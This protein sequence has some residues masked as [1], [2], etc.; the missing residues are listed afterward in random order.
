VAFRSV[1]VEIA[2]SNI[3]ATISG[4]APAQLLDGVLNP[5]LPR[6]NLSDHAGL[7]GYQADLGAS[8]K[9]R[10]PN[11]AAVFEPFRS[12]CLTGAL[13]RL[14]RTLRRAGIRYRIRDHRQAPGWR[15]DWSLSEWRLRDYQE[16]VVQAALDSGRGLIDIGTS[17]G[18]SLLAAAIVARIG[19]PALFLVTTRTL[20]RQTA[21]NLR[22]YLGIEPGI[23]GDGHCS[24]QTI[25]VAL[26]QALEQSSADIAPW[27]N[28]VLVFDEGHHA[29]APTYLDLIRRIDPR[30]H[31]YLSAV[32]FRSGADQTVLDALAGPPLT[33]RRYSAA[34]LIEK[35]YASP[36]EVRIEFGR[37]DG[38]MFEKPFPMLYRDFIVHHHGRNRR[39][40]E[41]AC[42]AVTAGKS[43]LVLVERIEHGQL[44]H[45][46]LES[47]MHA[48]ALAAKEGTRAEEQSMVEKRP[49]SMRGGLPP[50]S[51]H[52]GLPLAFVHGGIARSELHQATSDFR[53]GRLRCLI[54]TTGLFQE[55]VSIDGIHVL[56][57]A[58]GFKSRAKVIQSVGRG[59]RRCPGKTSCLYVDFW[60]DDATGIFRSHSRQ[61]LRVLKEEG[62]AL[63]DMRAVRSMVE[64]SQAGEEAGRDPDDPPQEPECAWSS[65]CDSDGFERAR[66][67]ASKEGSDEPIPPMWTHIP[68]TKR[69]LEIDADGRVRRRAVCLKK[70]L[71]PK[72]I[73]DKCKKQNLCRQGGKIEWQDA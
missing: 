38:N 19:L 18:K 68:R 23:I 70:H 53:A 9:A 21:E 37:I 10:T 8:S 56:V 46:W 5:H 55:G 36:I 30:Y 24:P 39:I 57:N 26:V 50:A 41:I 59:M 62:F 71:V 69:F 45:D 47:E 32:P 12:A 63:P 60:D 13:P 35:G 64:N 27:K 51:A 67:L 43:V 1:T 54:A 14:K 65:V 52:G 34:F 73:C 61:R 31:F 40:A 17:G 6:L 48:R 16:E 49:A 66:S 15:E 3:E 28:G 44:L 72:T 25:T 20:L 11:L 22:A 29:V 58:G 42:D 4:P 7:R 2:V 33:G